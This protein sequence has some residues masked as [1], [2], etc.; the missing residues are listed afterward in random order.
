SQGNSTTPLKQREKLYLL[1]IGYFRKIQ[2]GATILAC[3]ALNLGRTRLEIEADAGSVNLRSRCSY[4]YEFGCKLAPLCRLML[5][6]DMYR[7]ILSV[8]LLIF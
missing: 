4:F 3:Q 6:E 2:A 7:L 5:V 1:A 8:V